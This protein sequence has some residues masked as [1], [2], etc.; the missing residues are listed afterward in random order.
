MHAWKTLKPVHERSVLVIGADS[1]GAGNIGHEIAETLTKA[2][3]MV[4]TPSRDHLG[5]SEEHRVRSYVDRY[6]IDTLVLAN[7]TNWLDWFEDF[8]EEYI[9]RVLHDCLLASMIAS[10]AFVK[11]TIDDLHRKQIVFIGSMSYKSV[12]NGSS[13]YCA[14]KAG[15][16]QFAKC[17]S[18]ELA[19]KAYDVFCI[20][21]SN[22]ANTPMAEATI[23]GL[24]R[25]RGL[26]RAAAENYWSSVNP[27]GEWLTKEDIAGLVLLLCTGLAGGHL[28]GANI[29]L[30]GGQR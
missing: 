16:A 12:L 2:G 17:L 7:G 18:W 28:S 5:A 11:E 19:P 9:Y 21:P 14:A 3:M 30:A 13:V 4:F 25:Y 24:M 6:H 15:L 23:E 8:P 20:N 10:Q 29:D 1:H 22:T 26:D 27:R